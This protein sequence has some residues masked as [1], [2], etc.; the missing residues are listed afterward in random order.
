MLRRSWTWCLTGHHATITEYADATSAVLQRFPS[1]QI[2]VAHSLGG[3]AAVAAIAESEKT[4]V[5]DLVLLAPACSLSHVL[6]RWAAQRRVPE[7]VVL[8]V[9]SELDRRD[10][11]PVSHWDIRTLGIP[12]TVRVR[13]L[14]DPTDAAVPLRDSYLIAEAIPA[15]VHEVT[16]GTGHDGLIGS[17]EMRAALTAC[18]Q[19]DARSS[20]ESPS[21]KATRCR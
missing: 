6:E 3:I 19:P 12:R 9:Y 5:R 14:H 20:S 2:V 10:G 11:V 18:L 17:A 4:S 16:T 1:I 15:E 7:P 8:R 13:I 21:R